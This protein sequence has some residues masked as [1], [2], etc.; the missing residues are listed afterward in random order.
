[1][2]ALAQVVVGQESPTVPPVNETEGREIEL[3]YAAQRGLLV[4]THFASG[5]NHEQLLGFW[6]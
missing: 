5:R 4:L 6:K 1:M 2:S 3:K